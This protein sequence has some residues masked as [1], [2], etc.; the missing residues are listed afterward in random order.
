MEQATGKKVR[1]T[2]NSRN[3]GRHTVT[4]SVTKESYGYRRGGEQFDVYEADMRARPDLFRPLNPPPRPQQIVSS[5]SDQIA[6]KERIAQVTAERQGK[7]AGAVPAP[8][9]PPPPLAIEPETKHGEE[10]VAVLTTLPDDKRE[11]PIE[12]LDWSKTK[13]NSGHIKLLRENGVNTL[14]DVDRLGT[15]GLLAINGIGP[16]TIRALQSMKSRYDL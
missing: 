10:V 12:E 4:G 15:A 7:P 9:P 1:I 5:R 6:R 16:A 8:P 14:N 2:Y 3:S 11:W 13:V